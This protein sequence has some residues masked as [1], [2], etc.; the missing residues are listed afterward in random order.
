MLCWAAHRCGLAAL[1][2]GGVFR[3]RRCGDDWR[4]RSGAAAGRPF[5]TAVRPFRAAISAAGGTGVAA[6]GTDFAAR[7]GGL[8]PSK[9]HTGGGDAEGENDQRGNFRQHDELL[10]NAKD[11][12]T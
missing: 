1:R 9:H 2:L 5:K 12:L 4:G 10:E 3:C 6:I 8:L 7:L 11:R